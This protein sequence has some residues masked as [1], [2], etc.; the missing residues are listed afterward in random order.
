MGGS[1]QRCNEYKERKQPSLTGN[2]LHSIQGAVCLLRR[3]R[4][5]VDLQ[6]ATGLCHVA[7]HAIIHEDL[8][9]KKNACTVCAI[10]PD[11]KTTP[12]E[13]ATMQ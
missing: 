3:S 5:T 9:M 13:D 12:D 7:L 1:L 10:R 2:S 6:Q 8:K 11:A 4:A